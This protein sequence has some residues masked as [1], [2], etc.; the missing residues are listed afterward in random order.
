MATLIW[1]FAGIIILLLPLFTF[2]H[3]FLFRGE[4][5]LFMY[6]LFLVPL[7]VCFIYFGKQLGSLIS[8]GL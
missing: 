7:G 4:D 1:R 3:Y 6:S 5:E 2:L 8:K